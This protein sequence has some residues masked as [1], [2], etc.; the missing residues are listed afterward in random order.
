MVFSAVRAGEH[1]VQ[2]TRAGT[3]IEGS[4]FTVLILDT[5]VGHVDGVRVYGRGLTEG[6]VGRPCQFY[7]DTSNA[8]ELSR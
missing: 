4:S 5:E 2:V 3:D 7:I 6:L 1:R 8:G